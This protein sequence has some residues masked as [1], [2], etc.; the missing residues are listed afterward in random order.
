LFKTSVYAIIYVDVNNKK[1]RKEKMNR[2]QEKALKELGRAFA[3]C[4]KA[5]LCFVGMDDDLLAWDSDEFEE[6]TKDE[7]ICEQQYKEDGNQGFMV[8]THNCYIDSGGW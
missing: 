2:I 7:S 1:N 6:L 5:N 4:K 8:N 3:K